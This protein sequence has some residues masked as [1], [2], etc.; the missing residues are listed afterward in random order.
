MLGSQPWASQGGEHYSQRAGPIPGPWSGNEFV[1]EEQRS[2]VCQEAGL[3]W[4]KHG[5]R[6]RQ[7]LGCVSELKKGLG[8]QSSAGRHRSYIYQNHSSCRGGSALPGV[9]A[10]NSPGSQ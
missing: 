10:S 6:A 5:M 7:G 8:P 1:F 2:P 9:E 4:G 3:Q